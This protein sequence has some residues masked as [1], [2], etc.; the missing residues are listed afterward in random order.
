[1]SLAS[2]IMRKQKPTLTRQRLRDA[3][4]A[5]FLEKGWEA[6]TGE[7]IREAAEVSQGS[8]RHFFPGAKAEVASEI[9]GQIHGAVWCGAMANFE[10][11]LIGKPSASIAAAQR[12]FVARIEEDRGR[13]KL[14]FQL[15]SGL[16]QTSA[17]RKIN[18]QAR[19]ERALIAGWAE[20]AIL[21]PGA[22]PAAASCHGLVFGSAIELCRI[23]AMGETDELPSAALRRVADA[24]IAALFGMGKTPK[25]ATISHRPEGAVDSAPLLEP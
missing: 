11:P 10:L 18:D 9:Y 5:A 25:G 22:R 21:D 19:L 24:A 8:W 13:A 1:M 17:V 14:L 23:W 16:Q 15:Q 2:L 4:M 20:V 12:E 3:A 6:V 7:A